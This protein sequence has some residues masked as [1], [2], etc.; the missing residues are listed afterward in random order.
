MD[1]VKHYDFLIDEGNDPCKDPLPLRK[2]MEKWDGPK[3]IASMRLTGKEKVL[4]IG[5]GTGRIALKVLPLCRSFDGIDIS[6][7]TIARAEENLSHYQNKK[8]IC[9]DFLSFYFDN[10][11]DVVYSTLTIQHFED[12]QAFISKVSTLL[13]NMGFSACPLTEIK[14]NSLTWEPA[15]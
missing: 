4:E 12:K 2:Y 15:N 6:P 9:G 13:K 14:M 10:T 3:F 8:L 5:M 1:V 11:Y 7:K